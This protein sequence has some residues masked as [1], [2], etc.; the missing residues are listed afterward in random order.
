M[1][2]STLPAWAASWHFCDRS[3]DRRLNIASSNSLLNSWP[4]LKARYSI[5]LAIRSYFRAVRTYNCL[6]RFN[7]H[8]RACACKSFCSESYEFP[9]AV[10]PDTAVSL[11]IVGYLY[12]C[13]PW[14][15]IMYWIVCTC[16][17][18]EVRY[19]HTYI[20]ICRRSL[21]YRRKWFK[22]MSTAGSEPLTHWMEEQN[23]EKVSQLQLMSM[24][25]SHLSVRHAASLL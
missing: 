24:S 11:A 19:T 14:P 17:E 21:I 9:L 6:V 1:S 7:A 20:Y 15:L 3:F 25:F 2:H 10:A 4:F 22:H 18:V 12:C 23:S 16:E 13:Q 8:A 5:T